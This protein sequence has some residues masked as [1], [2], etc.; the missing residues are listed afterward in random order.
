MARGEAMAELV[1]VLEK[2]PEI[3]VVSRA[4]DYLLCEARR[5]LAMVDDV[6]FLFSPNQRDLEIRSS[7]REQPRPSALEP[8]LSRVYRYVGRLGVVIRMW[9]CRGLP[10]ARPKP[11]PPRQNPR[12]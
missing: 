1:A 9:M 10:S 7:S 2:Q 8:V 5:G 12:R 11:R 3:T 6:E 4:E